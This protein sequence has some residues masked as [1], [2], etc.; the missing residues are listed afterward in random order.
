LEQLL[1]V[2]D[3][4]QRVVELGNGPSNLEI[5]ATSGLLWKLRHPSQ[6]TGRTDVNTRLSQ[7][8]LTDL[9]RNSRDNVGA[10]VE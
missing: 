9:L 8:L 3:K 2:Y 1:D 10:F 7:D 5:D 6:D 4:Y